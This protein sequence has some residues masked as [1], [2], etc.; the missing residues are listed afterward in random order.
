MH[1]STP[2][3]FDFVCYTRAQLCIMWMQPRRA[4]LM[5]QDVLHRLSAPS[6][7]AKRP[8]F[9]L[10]WKLVFLPSSSG[11]SCCIARPEWGAPVY[12][13]SAARVRELRDAISRK[14]PHQ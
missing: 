6:R 10:V 5:D 2:G 4:L 9:S 11:Q 7:E 13:G 1:I 12:F 14:R 3:R 8:R